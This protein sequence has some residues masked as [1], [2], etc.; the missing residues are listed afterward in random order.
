MGAWSFIAPE[1]ETVMGEIGSRQR[2]LLYCGRPAAASPA[3]GLLRRHNRE[4]AQLI[5]AALTL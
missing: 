5:D 3:T 4:Q 1:I 2:R